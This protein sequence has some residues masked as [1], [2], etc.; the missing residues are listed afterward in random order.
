LALRP[1]NLGGVPVPQIFERVYRG[2]FDAG[3]F[4]LAEL[5]FYLS[6]NAGD[7]IGIPVFLHRMFRQQYIFTNTAANIMRP[8][9]LRGK[10]IAFPRIIQTATVWIRGHLVHDYGVS[11][12]DNRWYTVLTHHWE[13]EHSNEPFIPKDGST[14][15]ILTG[16]G[17]DENE[18]GYNALQEDRVDVLGTTQI[19]PAF[20]SGDARL[21]RLFE[22]FRQVEIAY[23]KN[24]GI[25]P[26]MHLLV[27]RKSI[28]AEHP[29]LA[30]QLFELFC[31]S[32]KLA[33]AR[34]RGDGS[35]GL[36]WKDH[37]I[38]EEQEIFGGDAWAYGLAKNQHAIGQFLTY[39]HDIGIA[40][41][42]MEAKDLFHP[43]TW[44]LVD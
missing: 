8:E 18:I 6:R 42:K 5:V 14:L 7:L 43:S 40:A 31:A 10:R 39:C 26:I 22:D 28:L 21:K 12:Q 25:F 13:D 35:L 16:P 29:D 17:K 30:R 15:E 44:E 32:K 41:R 9:D 33:N 37:Y 20:R 1:C 11:A 3:E 27:A 24:T 23:Y 34:L 2:E 19:P 38:K 36:A 4:S